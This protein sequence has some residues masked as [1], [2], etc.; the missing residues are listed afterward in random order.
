V[1]SA[2]FAESGPAGAH[3][4][5]ELLRTARE[6]GM[7]VI[8]PNSFGVINSHPDV[9]LNASLASELP[10]GGA[11]GLFAQ[12]GALGIAVLASAARRHLGISI[13]ASAGNR[14]DVS[15]NDFMQFW[16]D[17]EDTRAVGLYLESVGNPRKFSRIAR[18]LAMLKPVI[19]VKSGIS[20]YGVPPGH[21]VR[22]VTNVPPA[23]FDAMLRQAGVIRVENVY[24][25]LRR[26]PARDPP[27]PA[28][29][30]AG[31][32]RRQLRRPRSAPP[33]R[34]VSAG[35]WRSPTVRF[36]LPSEARAAEFADRP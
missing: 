33:P 24:Q 15:G 16:I 8:G 10:P 4:Q 28:T 7:R 27:A 17:D 13:F 23:A 19:V 18:Q 32:H 30:S 25:P 34:P 2:G 35:D 22:S 21:R 5:D 31:G 1:A 29:W 6:S 9:L 36:S 3:L 12:S 20:S 11:L 14:V 26:G